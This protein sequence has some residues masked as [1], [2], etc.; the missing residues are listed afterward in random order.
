MYFRSSGFLQSL[1]MSCTQLLGVLPQGTTQMDNCH[2][3]YK[4]NLKLI[5]GP[6]ARS[7]VCW[8]LSKR[9]VYGFMGSGV[10]SLP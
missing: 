7:R 8:G 3:G 4:E 2:R 6:A 10:N 1:D 5:L 9:S